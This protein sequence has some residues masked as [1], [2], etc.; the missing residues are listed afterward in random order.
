[1]FAEY[2]QAVRAAQSRN[3]DKSQRN[4][5]IH[6]N[7]LHEMDP[8][9]ADSFRGGDLDPFHRDDR[10]PAFLDHLEKLYSIRGYFPE[11]SGTTVCTEKKQRP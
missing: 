1:M 7:V 6:F 2:L 11:T 9:L 8:Q 3:T 5:Q 10:I 4:G